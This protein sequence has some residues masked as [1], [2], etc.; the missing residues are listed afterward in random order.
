MFLRR[1]G[2][3]SSS[4]CGETGFCSVKS[5]SFCFDGYFLTEIRGIL[6]A[7]FGKT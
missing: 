1:P 3:I 4:F 6:T 5:S 7:V 2:D